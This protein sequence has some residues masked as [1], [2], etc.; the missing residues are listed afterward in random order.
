M[1]NGKNHVSLSWMKPHSIPDA[2]PVLA[3]R[4]DAW[5]VGKDGG[6]RWK[7]LGVT[8][9]NSFDAFNLKPGSEYIF[10]VT[11]RNRYGWGDSAQTSYPVMVGNVIQLPEF[12][13]ILPGQLK[14]LINRTITLECVFKGY[15]KP[16]I[17]WYK[18]GIELESDERVSLLVLGSTCRLVISD[19]LENDTGR[20]TCEATNR[21]GRVSSFARLQVV[22]DPKIYEADSKLKEIIDINMVRLRYH[23][24]LD[25]V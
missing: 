16:D 20:Y 5:M 23:S 19:V 12:T 2:A 3:Y 13:K 10:R 22:T 21:Q 11:P 4:I 9:L 1:D 14:A 7:E 25:L 6:A 8:P 15:P 18:D 17:I 24:F